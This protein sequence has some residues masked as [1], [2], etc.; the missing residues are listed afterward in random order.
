MAEGFAVR[1][2]RKLPGP[3]REVARTVWMAWD[4]SRYRVRLR[5]IPARDPVRGEPALNYGWVLPREAGAIVHGGRVKLVHLDGRHPERAE[6]FNLLYLVSSAAVCHVDVLI[7]WARERGAKIVW[8]QNGVAYPGWAGER[9]ERINAPMRRALAMVDHVVYQ[10]RF[11]RESADIFLGPAPCQHS[12]IYNA[13]DTRTFSPAPAPPDPRPWRLLL[14]GSHQSFYRVESALKALAEVRA[15]GHE[16]VLRIAGRLDWNGAVEETRRAVDEL[17]LADAVEYSPAFTMAEAP[18]L[19]RAHHVLLHTKYNDPCPTVPIESMA[20][21]VPVVASASGG[22]PELVGED[23]GRLVPIEKQYERDLPLDAAAVALA[24]EEIMA[25]WAEA[26]RL[27]RAR[28]VECF[29]VE[30]WLD[31]HDALFARLLGLE[32]G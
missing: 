18:D 11:C 32:R 9:V 14:A 2:A 6:D 30:E 8:N 4:R 12:V 23:G 1:V 29:E 25:D 21:G 17:G 20:C 24:V 15:H 10:S 3:L 7:A 28:A 13:V 31:A 26:S 22:L 27:A 19:Y 16:A 5:G